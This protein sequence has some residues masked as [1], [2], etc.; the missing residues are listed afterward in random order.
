[1]LLIY[2]EEGSLLLR[3]TQAFLISCLNLVT[4]TLL[5]DRRQR[6]S[7]QN[8]K[9]CLVT[10][11]EASIHFAT[12]RKLD[13]RDGRSCREAERRLISLLA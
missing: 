12:A 9:D 5:Q 13:G 11:F 7:N 4:R 6:N 3:S 8:Q 2:S 10:R 1:M